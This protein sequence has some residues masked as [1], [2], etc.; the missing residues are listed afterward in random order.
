MAAFK[1]QATSD[2]PQGLHQVL[3][4]PRLENEP[5]NLS[6]IDGVH[7]ILEPC[8]A[9]E[10]D[11]SGPRAGSPGAVEELQSGFI[12]KVKVAEEDVHGAAGEDDASLFGRGGR[13][14]F[15]ICRELC[16]EKSQDS[17]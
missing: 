8:R 16:A 11:P 3:A 15:E 6:M 12:G 10:K 17:G 4:A 7:G 5:V 13:H 9:G 14:D 2:C 1:Q